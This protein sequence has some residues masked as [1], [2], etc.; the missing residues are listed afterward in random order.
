M[1]SVK[2]Q[3]GKFDKAMRRFKKTVSNEKVLEE[4]RARTC[5][6]KPT[7]K[8]HRKLAAAKARHRRQ[9]RLDSRP[10]KLY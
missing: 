2:V 10:P 9:I 8:R 5:Y 4:T 6:E 3:Y 1:I 7:T